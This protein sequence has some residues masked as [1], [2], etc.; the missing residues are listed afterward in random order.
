MKKWRHFIIDNQMILPGI[1]TFQTCLF[2][3]YLL[4]HYHFLHS[5]AEWLSFVRYLDGNVAGVI[6]IAI[7]AIYFLSCA[8]KSRVLKRVSIVALFSLWGFYFLTFLLRE[9]YGYYYPVWIFMLGML[10]TIYYEMREGDYR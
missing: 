5:Q 6:F 3:L 2:G 7:S 10:L 4:I 8:K 9:F 1:I